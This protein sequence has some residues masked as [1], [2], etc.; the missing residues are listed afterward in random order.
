M[1]NSQARR[2]PRR[3]RRTRV[4]IVGTGDVGERLAVMLL[5]RGCRVVAMVRR[6]ERAASLA[7]ALEAGLTTVIGDLDRPRSLRRVA[8]LADWVVHLAPPPSDGEDDP[9]TRALL[10][11]LARHL[12]SSRWPYQAPRSRFARP[13]R[14]GSAAMPGLRRWAAMGARA[15][16]QTARFPRRIAYVSTTGVYGDRGGD[17]VDEATPVRPQSARAR[18]RVAAERRLRQAALSGLAHASILRAPGIYAADR[19]PLE[20]LRRQ[21][22]ALAPDEDVYTNHV[23]ADD[24]ARSAWFALLRGRPAR[25]YNVVDQSE[26]RMGEYFDL[27]A[28]HFGLPRPPRLERAR[29][30]ELVSPMMLCFMSESRRVRAQRVARELRMRLRYPSVLAALDRA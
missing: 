30:A 6:P 23:H 17:W 26:L 27:I 3:F 19:L 13:A 9:R 2:T 5:A 22:P 20:R 10:D 21:L 14:A 28:D 24:L 15:P 4:L 1:N 16:R 25:V 29:L 8:S 18:R 11:A 7:G 12:A